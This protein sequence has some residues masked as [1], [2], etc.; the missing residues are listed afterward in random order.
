MQSRHLPTLNKQQLH[1]SVSMCDLPTCVNSSWSCAE[2]PRTTSCHLLGPSTC[3]AFS[4]TCLAC[5]TTCLSQAFRG[6]HLLPPEATPPQPPLADAC[7]RAPFL[8][9]V[10][11][12]KSIAGSHTDTC[13]HLTLGKS[14]LVLASPAQC[15]GHLLQIR[16]V[17]AT[18]FCSMACPPLLLSQDVL[19]VC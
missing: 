16:R 10:T 4:S 1:P 18:C 11:C 17:Q 14:Q 12:F 2:L 9:A 15:G 13:R 19:V 6:R 7:P 8:Q 3:L 5:S